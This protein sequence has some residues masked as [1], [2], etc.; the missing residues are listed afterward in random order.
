MHESMTIYVVNVLFD[1]CG[2]AFFD[3]TIGLEGLFQL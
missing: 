3:W 2:D 1:C